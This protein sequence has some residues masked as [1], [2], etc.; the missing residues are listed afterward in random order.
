MYVIITCKYEKDPM[1]NSREK[2]GSRDIGFSIISLWG[3]F[4][5][6]VAICSLVSEIFMFESLNTR[7]DGR[8][9][10]RLVYYKLNSEPSAQVS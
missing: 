4:S 6:L 10:A 7:T 1:K 2:V 8:T 3:F 9:P 5:D